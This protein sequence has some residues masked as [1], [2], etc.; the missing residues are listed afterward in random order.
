MACSL[1]LLLCVGAHSVARW[2]DR[3]QRSVVFYNVDSCPAV[4]FVEADGR[5]W[6]NYGSWQKGAGYL[7]R[8]ASNYWRRLHLLPPV[9]I[10]DDYHR[11]GFFRQQQILSYG[12]CRVGMI[13]DDR[14]RNRVAKSPLSLQ[15]LYICRGYGGSLQE[16]LA[17]FRPSHIVLDSSLSDYRKQKLIEE[18]NRQKLSFTSLSAKGSVC[19]LF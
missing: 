15:Y 10:S 2:S 9:E 14:W 17:L 19:F 13:T 5:S 1:C 6:L 8:T 12:E 4:H 11:E 18:C 16:L 7:R 3:P